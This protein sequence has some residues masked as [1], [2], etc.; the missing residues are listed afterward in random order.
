MRKIVYIL[1]FLLLGFILESYS[2]N[3]Q[4][5]WLS[6]LFVTT[7]VMI[8]FK[9][10][11]MGA[12]ALMSLT[13]ACLGKLLVLKDALLGFSSPVVW[14]V[15][16]AFFISKGMTKTGLGQRIGLFF[17]SKFGKTPL[18]LAYSLTFA[19]L[20][21]APTIPSVTARSAGVIYPIITNLSQSL[22][23]HPDQGDSARKIGAYLTLVTFQVTVV[24]SA[25]FLTAMAAN[26]ILA[27]L[28]NQLAGA[29]VV[30]FSSW[31]KASIVPGLISCLVI[32]YV[33]YFL[34]KPTLKDAS[35]AP[36]FAEK[37]LKEMGA[38]SFPEKMMSCVMLILLV[39]WV[40]GASYQV[41]AVLVAFVGL[42]ILLISEVLTWQDITEEK[43]AWDTFIW[44]SVLLMM[45]GQLK[46]IGVIDLVA[47]GF[48]YLSQS[49]QAHVSTL[50]LLGSY[51]YSHYFFAMTAAHVSAMF[52]P[53]AE[54]LYQLNNQSLLPVWQL[55][56]MS[57]LFGGLTHYSIGPA[58]I[59]YAYGY[60]PLKTWWR[61]G[62]LISVLNLA[63]WF[64]VGQYWWPLIGI[65]SYH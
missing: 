26:P 30:T 50:L 19:E 22:G 35:Q 4:Q 31:I 36:A 29:Q 58:P 41:S 16:S 28:T 64:I 21:I 32:P 23:S 6:S 44:F 12:V 57:S 52:L 47:Q 62:F 27:S 13:A 7:I 5:A 14:L 3:D 1:F 15:V 38:F 33:C 43:T 46:T 56:F 10:Y 42:S 8:I 34:E 2:L 9:P 37:K 49:L 11:P 59:L 61:V 54:A 53:F 51:F 40:F 24:T 60:V 25:M 20:L 55:I 45:A 39:G 65:L 48:I 18:S 17:I 63:I